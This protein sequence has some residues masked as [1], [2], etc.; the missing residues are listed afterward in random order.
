[1]KSFLKNIIKPKGGIFGFLLKF[2]RHSVVFFF[3]KMTKKRRNNG[4]NKTN[5]GLVRRVHCIFSGKL[6]PKD[7]AVTRYVIRNIIENSS[8]KDV[9]EACYYD[10]YSLPKI[11]FKNVYSIEA[12]IHNRIVRVRSKEGRRIR[13]SLK[14]KINK[15]P[16][17]NQLTSSL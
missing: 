8:L 3:F 13:Q 9:Q 7:K 6:I 10:H 16:P 1:M 2:R 5:R 12:A 11:Y 15:I 17:G 14:P 4:R